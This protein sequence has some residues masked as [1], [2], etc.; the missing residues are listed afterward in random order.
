MN[1]PTECP[2]PTWVDMVKMEAENLPAEDMIEPQRELENC[3][4]VVGELDHQELKKY[5]TL[6]MRWNREA[7]DCVKG[8]AEISDA[9]AREEELTIAAELHKKSQMI[10]DISWTSLKD[11]YRL[12]DKDSIGIRRGWR[13]IYKDPPPPE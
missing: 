4:H 5:F 8:A 12:W 10:F 1:S 7:A 6:A 3:E 11:E 9:Q 13:V 2:S